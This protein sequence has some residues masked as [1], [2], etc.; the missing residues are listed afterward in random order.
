M[1]HDSVDQYTQFCCTAG[2]TPRPVEFRAAPNRDKEQ[3]AL[4]MMVSILDILGDG[5]SAVYTFTS[6]TT[7]PVT[8]PMA[9]CGKSSRLAA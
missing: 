6:Q 4:K 2:S 7:T 5:L 3:G 9:C 1:D 8:A